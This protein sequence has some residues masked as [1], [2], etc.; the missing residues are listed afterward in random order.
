MIIG[1]ILSNLG[2]NATLIFHIQNYFNYY[3]I[4]HAFN[5]SSLGNQQVLLSQQ[6]I[7]PILLINTTNNLINFG[8]GDLLILKQ[9]NW[10]KSTVSITYGVSSSVSLLLSSIY[11]NLQYQQ[12]KLLSF[13]LEN[14]LANLCSVLKKRTSNGIA[15]WCRS[16]STLDLDVICQWQVSYI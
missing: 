11:I 2:Q 10:G 8:L 3:G 13:K 7:L 6:N 14:F 15:K 4:R 16:H 12:N 9:N 5:L 1:F